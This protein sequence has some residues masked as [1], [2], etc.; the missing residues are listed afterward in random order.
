MEK[1][2]D[3]G[4]VVVEIVVKSVNIIQKHYRDDIVKAEVI[5]QA[6]WKE[7][8][9]LQSGEPNWNPHVQILNSFG[10]V[11]VASMGTS[12]R[13]VKYMAINDINNDDNNNNNDNNDYDSFND[14]DNNDNDNNS[15]ERYIYERKKFRGNFAQKTNWSKFPFDSQVIVFSFGAYEKSLPVYMKVKDN[16]IHFSRA[17][18]SSLESNEYRIGNMKYHS[19]TTWRKQQIDLSMVIFRLQ[20]TI[21]CFS[22]MPYA[23]HSSYSDYRLLT[24]HLLVMLQFVAE[25]KYKSIRP[26]GLGFSIL[27]KYHTFT[28]IFIFFNL[29]VCN[30]ILLNLNEVDVSFLNW[31]FKNDFLIAATIMA[32]FISCNLC[33]LVFVIYSIGMLA[34]N[35]DQDL[36]SYLKTK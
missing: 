19:I 24:E 36:E 27:D 11:W 4:T 26:R 34:S 31:F 5:I 9:S 10:R 16:V 25:I 33:F 8:S 32:I 29:I 21:C 20:F 22:M 14:S 1:T 3:S 2:D 15:G 35:K 18:T 12:K 30:T 23:M 6:K 28:W 7:K 17:I 13:D